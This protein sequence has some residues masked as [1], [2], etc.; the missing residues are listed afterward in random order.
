VPIE[1]EAVMSE[2]D[3]RERR[4]ACRLPVT[5]HRGK[6]SLS[7]E[8]EDVGFRGVYVVCDD[9]PAVRNLVRLTF[10]LPGV[11]APVEVHGMVVHVTTEDAARPR[12]FGLQFWGLD[13]RARSAWDHFVHGLLRDSGPARRG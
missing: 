3:R 10:A 12:G 4:F 5:L 8:T 6:G 2:I 11:G 9:P 13:A 7:L 1:S